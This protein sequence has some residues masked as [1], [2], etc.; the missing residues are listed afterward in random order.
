MT[1]HFVNDN[2]ELKSR[3]A[4]TEYL[5]TDHNG[6]NIALGLRECLSSWGLKEEDQTCITTD[7][8]ANFINAMELNE[9]TRPSMFWTQAAF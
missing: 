3:W 4:Q 9:R 6:V 8:A 2:L 7:N 1:V 5:P